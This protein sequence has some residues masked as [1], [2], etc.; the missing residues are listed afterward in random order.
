MS[1]FFVF[2]KVPIQFL[3]NFQ[4]LH[5]NNATPANMKT[6]QQQF[7]I[8]ETERLILKAASTED[9][10]F[11]FELLN[12]PK[13]I[14]F[15]G[16]R[17]VH[18]EEEAAQYILD[19][20][21]PQ[22]EKLGFGNYIVILKED[23]SKIGTCGLF[24]RE[25]LEGIDL[26]FAFLPEYEQKGYGFESSNR[27]MKAGFEEIKIDQINAITMTTNFSSQKLLEKLGMTQV[28]KFHLPNDPE[29]LF[30]YSITKK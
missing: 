13:W 24:D 17:N 10:A 27:L 18:S 15:I 28:G 3:Q 21:L 29:E 11:I 8:F 6:K 2:R 1:C 4:Y 20:M 22:Y 26:G 23:N 25:G 7:P 16:D 19:R 30:L 12:T 5:H 14:E 9:A